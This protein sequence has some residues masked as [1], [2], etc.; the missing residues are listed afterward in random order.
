MRDNPDKLGSPEGR[1]ELLVEAVRVVATQTF[2]TIVET[3]RWRRYPALTIA[4]DWLDDDRA[5]QVLG[6]MRAT[7]AE[8]YCPFVDF[9]AGTFELLGSR[10][11]LP[12]DTPTAPAALA[13]LTIALFEGLALQHTVD[14]T[15]G[16]TTYPGGWTLPALGF[17]AAVDPVT[18]P[19]RPDS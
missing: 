5:E 10:A 7:E 13:R 17:L 14:P 11:R 15:V 8:F 19:E 18:Q 9:Y 6:T 4:A 12:F 1:R 3:R 16:E 2:T